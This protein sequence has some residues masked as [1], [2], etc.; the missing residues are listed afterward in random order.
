MSGGNSVARMIQYSK[1]NMTN[2]HGKV[3]RSIL[4]TIRNTPKL[5]RKKLQA[6]ADAFE[7]R[8]LAAQKNEEKTNN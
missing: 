1:P 5:D 7:A 6:E 2:L 4:K 8:I 3:G